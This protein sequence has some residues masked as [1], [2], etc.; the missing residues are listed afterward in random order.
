MHWFLQ[1]I[2]F[3]VFWFYGWNITLACFCEIPLETVRKFHIRLEQKLI[4]SFHKYDKGDHLKDY[5][6]VDTVVGL[7]P[8]CC[9]GLCILRAFHLWQPSAFKSIFPRAI[10]SL[11][12]HA[13]KINAATLQRLT[14]HESQESTQALWCW[15]GLPVPLIVPESVCMQRSPGLVPVCVW[16]SVF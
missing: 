4:Y 2:T 9:S 13:K 5:N 7:Q 11:S 16:T 1:N 8:K 12:H 15:P 6:F 3:F 14:I 10:D